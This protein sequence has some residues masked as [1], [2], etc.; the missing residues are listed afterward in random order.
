[1]APGIMIPGGAAEQDCLRRW[2]RD[3][4]V[5]ARDHRPVIL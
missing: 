2:C 1:M 4:G 3:P 5:F